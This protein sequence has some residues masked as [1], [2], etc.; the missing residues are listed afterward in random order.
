ML[1]EADKKLYD[2]L[3]IEQP[4]HV[5]HERVKIEAHHQ[6]TQEGNVL[7]C[8]CELGTHASYVPTDVLLK[9]TDENGN[10][11]LTKISIK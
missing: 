11:I 8:S 9:G 10:P 5:T 1:H 3:G 2:R 6:W 7:K 4:S